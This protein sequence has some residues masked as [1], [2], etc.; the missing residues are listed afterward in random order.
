[1]SRTPG[2]DLDVAGA[3]DRLTEPVSGVE[4][5]GSTGRIAREQAL[6]PPR[7]DDL[8]PTRSESRFAH[9]AEP[10]VGCAARPK[11]ARSQRIYG[12][13]SHR[14]SCTGCPARTRSHTRTPARECR[15]PRC[16]AHHARSDESRRDRPP[17]R[18][19]PPS[20]PRRNQP[21]RR[22]P[23]PPQGPQ[24]GADAG[25]DA[26]ATWTHVRPVT[27]EGRHEPTLHP[28]GAHSRGVNALSGTAE[29]VPLTTQRSGRRRAASGRRQAF[30]QRARR[31]PA[32][33]G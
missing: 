24:P 17:L 8:R 11:P 21:G 29:S 9:G 28:H 6:H 3:E 30:G 13:R 19:T 18:S 22:V 32:A 33:F 7:V 4:T 5:V 27:I 25:R 20:Q 16:A 12:S 26:T 14:R 2:D 23:S 1:M 31:T 10:G 15:T